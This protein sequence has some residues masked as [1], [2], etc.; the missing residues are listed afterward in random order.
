MVESVSQTVF[1]DKDYIEINLDLHDKE[2]ANQDAEN[3]TLIQ[4]NHNSRIIRCYLT[5]NF[6]L[7][8]MDLTNS[9]LIM[10]VKKADLTLVMLQGNVTNANG[11]VVEFTLTRQALAI[12]DEIIC[13]VVK[14]GVDKSTMSFPHFSFQVE[15]T[16]IDED[17]IE[18]TNE[19]RALSDMLVEIEDLKNQ[20]AQLNKEEATN[21]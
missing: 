14:T 20:L 8:P 18:S 13:E 15:K 21:I 9:T 7:T 2:R 6:G 11:G 5:K 10:Y 16:I 1:V 17:L 12:A 19:F 4:G 3:Y